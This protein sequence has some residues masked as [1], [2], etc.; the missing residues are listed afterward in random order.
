MPFLWSITCLADL[1]ISDVFYCFHWMHHLYFVV[2]FTWV[3]SSVIQENLALFV[4]KC[5]PDAHAFAVNVPSTFCLICRTTSSPRKAWRRGG[6]T[7]KEDSYKPW[8]YPSATASKNARASFLYKALSDTRAL[9]RV[10]TKRDRAA[11]LHTKSTYRRVPG[12]WS[13]R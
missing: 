6:H 3:V 4:G 7:C 11:R 1:H 5:I 13:R 12:A 10:H 9:C 2:A 8:T